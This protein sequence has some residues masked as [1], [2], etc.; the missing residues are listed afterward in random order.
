MLSGIRAYLSDIVSEILLLLEEALFVVLGDV[1][2][3]IGVKRI[4][5]AFVLIV[6]A[7]GA[8]LVYRLVSRRFAARFGKLD[9]IAA[10]VEENSRMLRQL[11]AEKGADARDAA[12]RDDDDDDTGPGA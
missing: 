10:G 1:I 9:R 5:L 3:D 4:V 7:V 6:M 8:L 12:A 11:L 2:Y